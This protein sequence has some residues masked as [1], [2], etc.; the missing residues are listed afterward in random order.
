M[1]RNYLAAAL[2]N[3]VRNR[4]YAGINIVGLAI[5]FAAAMF[6]ILFAR[7]EFSYDKWLPDHER[8]YLV[9][10]SEVYSSLKPRLEAALFS[11]A[12]LLKQDFPEIEATTRLVPADGGSNNIRHG[13]I[14]FAEK[15]WWAE[16]NLFDLLKLPSIAGDLTTALQAPDGVVLSRSMA[17]KYFGRD[18]PVGEVLEFDRKFLMRVTGVME[19]L[20]SNTHLDLT[21]IASAVSAKAPRQFHN[22][23][24]Y[25]PFA[26]TY[27]RLAEEASIA[28]LRQNLPNF[29]ARHAQFRDGNSFWVLAFTSLAD[30]HLSAGAAGIMKDRGTASTAYGALVIAVLI[31]TIASVNFVNLTTARAKQRAV[32]IGVRKSSGA[33]RRH[34][35]AQFVLE[36]V[37]YATVGMIA[38]ALAVNVL[39]S[40]F[41]AY[42]QRKIAIDHIADPVLLAFMA[43]V[44]GAFAGAYPAFALSR[45]AP[46]GVLKGKVAISGG[47]TRPILVT[48]QFAILIVLA[49]VAVTIYR[50]SDYGMHESLRFETAQVLLV[51]RACN[52]PFSAKVGTLGGVIGSACSSNSIVG[53]GGPAIISGP[54]EMALSP[55]RLVIDYEYFDLYGLKPIAGRLF[56]RD[57]AGD[58]VPEGASRPGTPDVVIVNETLSRLLGFAVPEDALGRSVTWQPSRFKLVIPQSGTSEIVGVAPN[59]G[60][61]GPRD[62]I[63]P[64][65]YWIDPAA[66]STLNLKLAG[67]QVPETLVA[68]DELWK[69]LGAARPISRIFLNDQIETL[70]RDIS[71]LSQ[72]VAA[73]AG[74]AV[75]VAC[76]GLFGLAA[77]EAVQRTK[78]IGVRKA[79]GASKVDIL[80][81]MLWQFS[82]PVLWASLVAWPVAYFIMNRWLES[83]ADRVDIGLWT[84]PAAS[85]LTLLIAI[86]TVAGHA[87]LVARAQPVTALR[88]E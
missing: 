34:L 46:A 45:L 2:R 38:A 50:Q 29:T 85:A 77:S 22:A 30:I 9:S 56:L 27:V 63:E 62:P 71:R 41:N 81:L 84:F 59:F 54:G 72:L 25:T 42:L 24:P 47:Y 80:G 7:D 4:L 65:M 87:I 37:V 39:L 16:P 5:G 43:F 8:T 33:L 44:V 11:T 26:L 31:L 74:V 14:E 79:L 88:Y 69:E 10:S 1:F 40:P 57:R 66:H 28:A 21:I 49:L 58:A 23:V 18:N 67:D 68:I 15:V 61:G 86:A 13:N 55:D 51:N 35:I 70:Y 6:I 75:F 52:T 17:R 53:R 78:E 76:L 48:V 73:F 20:P 12:D 82:R 36:S 19:D 83:F 32:E 60:R 3:L 64:Q